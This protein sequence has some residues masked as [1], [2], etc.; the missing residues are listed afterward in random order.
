MGVRHGMVWAGISMVMMVC[1]DL[2]APS[3]M[4]ANPAGET[5]IEAA[6][7][8]AML[9]LLLFGIATRSRWV[10][11]RQTFELRHA[12]DAAQGANTAKSEFLANMSHEIRTPMNGVLGMAVDFHANLTPVFHSILTP[13]VAV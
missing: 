10:A 6:G 11:E 7:S 1:V 12:R 3:L 2:L 9:V 8:R 4:V 13:P 5:V